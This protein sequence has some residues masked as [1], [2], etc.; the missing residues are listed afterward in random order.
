MRIYQKRIKEIY[1]TIDYK[2]WDMNVANPELVQY[3]E[4]RFTLLKHLL[5]NI[6]AIGC[7][8]LVIYTFF[9]YIHLPEG[10]VRYPI[11]LWFPIDTSG[12]PEHQIIFFLCMTSL[13]LSL[14]GNLFYDF[15]F[16][17]A[18]Q[19]TSAQFLILGDLLRNL[20]TGV[21]DGL[22]DMEKFHGKEFQKIVMDRLVICGKHHVV[23]IQFAQ[24]I[25]KFAYFGLL[26]QV[27]FFIV[28]LVAGIVY[29]ESLVRRVTISKKAVT[30]FLSFSGY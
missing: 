15:L 22:S 20:S 8:F 6:V 30:N 29:M 26:G 11:G 13:Y 5:L 19:H 25:K 14:W 12:S 1:E 24:L 18:A 21:M 10:T 4:F 3:I 23:L 7:T 17:Y 27:A 9:P 28:I 2:F 16:I